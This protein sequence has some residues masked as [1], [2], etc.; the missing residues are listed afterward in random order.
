MKLNKK[1]L[2]TVLVSLAVAS[3]S[4]D[5]TARDGDLS[6]EGDDG[7]GDADTDADSDADSDSD[8]DEGTSIFGQVNVVDGQ[9]CMIGFTEPITIV[10]RAF[11]DCV[12][13]IGQQQRL[14]G[15]AVVSDGDSYDI[16][17]PSGGCYDVRAIDGSGCF[18][19]WSEILEIAEG[20][21]FE[22][23]IDLTCQCEPD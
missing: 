11:K 18:L 20:E 16:V 15:E 10:I 19:G 5:T 22:F 7:A 21:A 3:C 12:Y 1:L 9:T 13:V 8:V 4:D 23:D 17:L 14:G 2:L 6:D